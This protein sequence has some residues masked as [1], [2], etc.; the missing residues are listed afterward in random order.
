MANRSKSARRTAKMA[1]NKGGA[2]RGVFPGLLVAMTI[3]EVRAFA[4]RVGVLPLGSTEP[5]GP[6]LPYGTDTFQVERLCA[7]AAEAAN[8]R[9]ARAL[10]YPA[11]PI[12]NNANMRAFPFACRVGVRTLVQAL[13][14]IAKQAYEDGL[15]KFVLVNG[16]GG[17]PGA[18]QATLREISGMDAMPFTC[19]YNAFE[20]PEMTQIC[21]HPGCHG[22][23]MET[24]MVMA[25]RPDLVRLDKFGVFPESQ[26]R[27]PALA[28]AQFVRPWNRYLPKSAGG[29]VRL[30]SAAKGRKILAVEAKYIEDLLVQ[31]AEAELDERFPYT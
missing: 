6:H 18:V 5:H 12:T 28:K 14:D 3:D 21:E 24:S 30:S 10:L 9:G 27:I 11:L 22:D 29:D 13:I 26:L 17:N 23:E 8:A 15:R 25:L 19:C 16:H 20:S 2:R 1:P 7:L 31:L 4:P